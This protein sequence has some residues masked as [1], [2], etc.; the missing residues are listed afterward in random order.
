MVSAWTIVASLVFS[1]PTV[2]D[3]TLAG[4]LAISGLALV[5]LIAHELSLHRAVESV[6][7]GSGERDTRLATAT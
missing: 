5:G 7:D 6:R 4:A 1:L 2:H 3:P